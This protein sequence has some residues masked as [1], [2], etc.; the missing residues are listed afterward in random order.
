MNAT[1]FRRLKAEVEAWAEETR[2]LLAACRHLIE[3][4]GTAKELKSWDAAAA[5]TLGWVSI[6]LDHIPATRAARVEGMLFCA[7]NHPRKPPP[8]S[9]SSP[10]HGL[11]LRVAQ[12][13]AGTANWYSVWDSALPTPTVMVEDDEALL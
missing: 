10:N 9:S 6:A 4:F 2:V 12:P 5:P 7:K 1:S 8:P 3:H 11:T 13:W